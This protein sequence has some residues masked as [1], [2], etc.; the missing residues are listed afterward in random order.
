[1]WGSPDRVCQF[2]VD[3]E[4]SVSPLEVDEI[5]RLDGGNLWARYRLTVS[6]DHGR[7]RVQGE[8]FDFGDTPKRTD[9]ERPGVIDTQD[10]K[11]WVFDSGDGGVTPFDGPFHQT[12]LESSGFP[13]SG[14]GESRIYAALL[15]A[16]G[17]LQTPSERAEGPRAVHVAQPVVRM[18]SR[19]MDLTNALATLDEDHRTQFN[20]LVDDFRAE[21]PFVESLGF[22]TV[23]PGKRVLKWK[24]AKHPHEWKYLEHFSEGMLA[25][26]SI[27]AALYAQDSPHWIGFDEPET[28]LH[29]RLLRRVV[30]IM[31]GR[32]EKTPIIVATHSDA[33]LDCLSEPADA[34]HIVESGQDGSVIRKLDKDA[35]KAWL[36]EFRLG[37]LRTNGHLDGHLREN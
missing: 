6:D 9:G 5:T 36:E 3:T 13:N 15:T 11:R 17:W 7:P 23:P 32:A 34:V 33:L 8:Y 18:H 14:L 4:Q 22:Q 20:R 10:G 29:P 2:E 35:L 28:H 19:G 26:L 27:L 25:Y 12:A 24:H 31:E 16:S 30:A 37:E 1:M 21:L